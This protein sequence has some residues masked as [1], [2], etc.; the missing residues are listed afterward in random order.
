MPFLQILSSYFFNL[1]EFEEENHLFVLALQF[2]R[3]LEKFGNDD[4]SI[5]NSRMNFEKR[6]ISRVK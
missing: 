5:I 3:R 6:F 1:N 4:L 2:V